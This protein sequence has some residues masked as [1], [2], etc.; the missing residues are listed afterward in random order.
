MDLIEDVKRQAIGEVWA[1][2]HIDK[3]FTFK[4]SRITD[5]R[6]ARG[7]LRMPYSNIYMPNNTERFVVYE[8]GQ[9]SPKLLGFE[10]RYLDWVRLDEVCKRQELVCTLHLD[11]LIIPNTSVYIKRTTNRNFIMAIRREPN[12]IS[13]EKRNELYVRFYSNAWYATPE[14][15]T[16]ESVEYYGGLIGT[17]V[18]ISDLLS[19]W[20]NFRARTDGETLAFVD[21]YYVSKLT[22]AMLS[23]GQYVELYYDG[24][25]ESYFDVY[26]DNL[27]HYQSTLDN[28]RKLLIMSPDSLKGQFHFYDDLDFFICS[29]KQTNGVDYYHGAYYSRINHRDVRQVTQ[30]DWSLS[31]EKVRTVISEQEGEIVY[32]SAFIRVFIRKSVGPDPYLQNGNYTHDLFLLPFDER[33][34]L[35]VGPSAVIDEWRAATLE[36]SAY[37]TFVSASI[38]DI[39]SV[40]GVYSFYGADRILERVRKDHLDRF[41][42]P[43][44]LVNGGHVV[45]YDSDGLVIQF[46]RL[47]ASDFNPIYTASAGTVHV[48][49]YPGTPVLNATEL[50]RPSFF[51]GDAISPWDEVRFVRETTGQWEIAEPGRH[52]NVQNGRITWMPQYATAERLKRD[53]S[54][55]YFRQ[56]TIHRDDIGLPISL[57][58]DNSVSDSGYPFK[59]VDVWM[60]N[61][62]LVRG[63]DYR[64]DGFTLTPRCEEY[65]TGNDQTLVIIAHGVPPVSDLPHWGFVQDRQ[66]SKDDRFNLHLFRN[67]TIVADGKRYDEHSLSYGEGYQGINNTT[68]EVPSAIREGALFGIEDPLS[69]VGFLTWEGLAV[70]EE[71]AKQ[72]TFEIESYLTKVYQE[73][74]DPPTIIIPYKHTV[75]SEGMR[76]VLKAMRD[77]VLNITRVN[78]SDTAMGAYLKPYFTTI[79]HD[80]QNLNVHHGY[81]EIAAHASNGT[82]TLTSPEYQF[83]VRMN[84]I[85]YDNRVVLNNYFV[86]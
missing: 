27:E 73:R 22:G 47:E 5:K 68:Q 17:D 64:V 78:L 37:N 13:I 33:E 69:H 43:P 54:K 63:V 32:A 66:I 40:A 86:V 41:I 38:K 39:D 9:L 45:E 15:Q 48:D 46:R 8:M 18:T 75:V 7:V 70:S 49:F 25:I 83:F 50:D 55:Y 62:R 28:T 85:Y 71:S 1:N 42:M 60:N 80:V 58:D 26:L 44:T 14:G 4:P 30:Q 74:P 10:G 20:N 52:W 72:R 11:F 34:R 77:G 3:Q 24:S 12:R 61:R 31:S 76:Q 6:G 65:V 79:T 81:I 19:K 35:M 51:S 57:F 29:D 53:A 84:E 16:S 59:R 21:G 23:T 2:P 56:L 67:K 36:E 82:I